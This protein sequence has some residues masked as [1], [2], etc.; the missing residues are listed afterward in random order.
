MRK[1]PCVTVAAIVAILASAPVR[2]EMIGAT[3]PGRTQAQRLELAFEVRA[4][5]HLAMTPLFL[6]LPIGISGDG[7]FRSSTH[8]PQLQLDTRAL[9]NALCLGASCT[10]RTTPVDMKGNPAG[11]AESERLIKSFG[12]GSAALALFAAPVPKN[13]NALAM[14]VSP[15]FALG[16]GGL[17]MR[18]VWW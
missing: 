10:P 5:M 15:M 3:A 18:M 16:G 2:A 12:L 11:A 7:S 13:K 17:E 8:A 6:F 1:A 9:G 4:D 14:G